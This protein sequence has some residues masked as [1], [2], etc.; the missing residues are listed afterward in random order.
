MR[1]TKKIYFAILILIVGCYVVFTIVN[2]QQTL[3][4]YSKDSE[5]L[6]QQIAEQNEYK[7]KLLAE[8]ENVDSLDFIEQNAREKLDMYY[9]NERVYV[10]QAR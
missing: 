3:N 9:P 4:Q 5:E 2:Q 1:K 7:E 10:D 8:K 6:S